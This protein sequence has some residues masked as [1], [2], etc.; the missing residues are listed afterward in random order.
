MSYHTSSYTVEEAARAVE[1]GQNFAVAI[2]GYVLRE[3][4][5]KRG[6]STLLAFRSR[7]AAEKVLDRL[8]YAMARDAEVVEIPR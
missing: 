5:G 1:Y 3:D 4:E 6:R 2:D 8:P 7:S